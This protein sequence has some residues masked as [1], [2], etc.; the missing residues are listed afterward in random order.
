MYLPATNSLAWSTATTENMRLNSTGDL[1]VGTNAPLSRLHVYKDQTSAS[2]STINLRVAG[3]QTVASTGAF[4]TAQLT[5]AYTASSGNTLATLMGLLVDPTNGG[6]GTITVLHGI[7]SGPQNTSTGTVA[8]IYGVTSVPANKG[9][10]VTNA[11]GIL[12]RVDNNNVGGTITSVY[13]VYIGTPSNAGTIVNNWGLYQDHA[14]AKNALLGRTLIGG[15]TDDASTNLQVNGTFKVTGASTLAA[16]S[17]T[18][19]AFSGGIT[20]DTGNSYKVNNVAVVGATKPGWTAATGTATRTTFVTS[21]VTTEQLAQRV[22]ALL[23]DL[24]SH[25]LIGT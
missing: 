11:Y 2:G 18:T 8:N 10:T 5:G 9:G 21:T 24:I 4:F 25:G 12:A 22:K 20:V 17:A 7:S 13:G 6:T 23:D 1:G 14:A 3:S 16:L 15:L 19:G